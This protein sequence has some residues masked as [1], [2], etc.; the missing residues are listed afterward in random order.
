MFSGGSGGAAAAISTCSL[1]VTDLRSAVV[2][3]A[4]VG[5]GAPLA[6]VVGGLWNFSSVVA[7]GGRRFEAPVS[8][9]ARH[10]AGT[11]L[12]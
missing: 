8:N 4:V 7:G 6:S 12:C 5:A 3:D 1:N 10:C 11:I 9:C 2:A